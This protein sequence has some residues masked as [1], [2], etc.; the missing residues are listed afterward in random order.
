MRSYS[1]SF[2]RRRVAEIREVIDAEAKTAGRPA[3]RLTVWVPVALNPGDAAR[4]QLSAQL[5][6]YLAPPGYGEMFSELGFLDLVQRARAG[7]KRAQLAAA[8][9]VELLDQ[10]CALGSPAGIAATTTGLPRRRRRHRGDRAIYCRGPLRRR[11]AQ[12]GGAA[13][14]RKPGDVKG[15]TRQHAMP[16]GRAAGRPTQADRLDV[17]RGAGTES[18]RR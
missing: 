8:V 11:H 4:G 13:T 9:P 3:P 14:Q 16:S 1:I 10:V 2:R 5:A 15:D 18:G 7:A 12:C 17:H 6:V